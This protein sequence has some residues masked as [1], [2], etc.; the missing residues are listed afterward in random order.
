MLQ[1]FL[2]KYL[3]DPLYFRQLLPV[4]T[5]Q[6]D[7]AA[8]RSGTALEGHQRARPTRPCSQAASRLAACPET[9]QQA[10]DPQES[11]LSLD[12]SAW[13]CMCPLSRALSRDLPRRLMSIKGNL[14]E[15]L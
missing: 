6:H 1:L 5:L 7:G 13:T 2:K 3:H 15:Q 9:Q 4:C 12:T 14:A 11:F 8:E 10:S